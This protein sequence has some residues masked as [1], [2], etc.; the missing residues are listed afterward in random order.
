MSIHEAGPL[1]F[2]NRRNVTRSATRESSE[3]GCEV[4]RGFG[5]LDERLIFRA[6]PYSGQPVARGTRLD[7]RCGV[8]AVLPLEAADVGNAVLPHTIDFLKSIE[9]SYPRVSVVA[10]VRSLPEERL[11]EC[12]NAIM[13]LPIDGVVTGVPGDRRSSLGFALTRVEG[14]A[15]RIVRWLQVH[16]NVMIS[17]LQIIRVLLD[18]GLGSW[19]SART[20][21][22]VTDPFAR[23]G[24]E[25]QTR[26]AW[27]TLGKALRSALKVQLSR[28][29]DSGSQAVSIE[30]VARQVGFSDSSGLYRQ[31]R[32]TFARSPAWIRERL[33]WRWLLDDWCRERL[34]RQS[35]AG[36]ADPIRRDD[37]RRVG[38]A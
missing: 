15:D 27:F 13:C 22:K 6:P 31:F 11:L 17:D 25:G 23:S 21:P 35:K 32:S 3:D 1:G 28:I 36:P 20:L 5:G 24:V 37:V 16:S 10:E 2:A 4:R 8:V 29:A 7:R 34:S 33:G 38:G 9:A 18:T 19:P 26:T 12:L 14:L 30:N